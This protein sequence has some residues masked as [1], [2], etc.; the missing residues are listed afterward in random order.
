MSDGDGFVVFLIGVLTGGVI[1]VAIMSCTH[2]PAST[3]EHIK[4]S[5]TYKV[6]IVAEER[7]VP[8][9]PEKGGV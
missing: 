9:N 4:N 1:G 8:V 7:M 6:T 5:K 2:I 3:G